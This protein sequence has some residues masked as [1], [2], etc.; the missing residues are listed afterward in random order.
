MASDGGRTLSTAIHV[1]KALECIAAN[2]RGVSVKAIARAVEL[3]LS[4]AYALVNSLRTEGFV[5]PLQGAPGLYVLGGRTVAMYQSYV[6]SNLQPERLVSFLDELRDRTSARSYVAMWKGGDVEVAEIRGRRGARELQDI[7][8]GFRGAAHA[9]ALGKTYLCELPYSQW[10]AYLQTP[11]YKRYS[12]ATLFTR[13]QLHH[14]LGAVRAR[15]IA[16]DLEEYSQGVCCLAA[17]VRAQNGRVIAAMGISVPA[18]RFRA[19]YKMLARSVREISAL[20]S[21][22]LEA[23]LQH[24]GAAGPS[25]SRLSSSSGSKVT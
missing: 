3:S 13:T 18:R 14:N 9:L 19:Q 1:L 2:P 12:P 6:E 4:S 25:D 10:P 11:V 23:A 16:F 8:K 22:E 21:A 7:S 5:E 20:A 24:P 17:P 15:G